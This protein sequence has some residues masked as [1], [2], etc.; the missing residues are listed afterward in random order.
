MTKETVMRKTPR[1]PFTA[2][3]ALGLGLLLLAGTAHSRDSRHILSARDAMNTEAAREQLDGSVRFYFAGEKTPAIASRMMEV[4]A[5]RK[6][7][8]FGKSDT[9]A[10]EWVFLSSLIALRD[11]A[12]QEGGN[13][14]VDI[15]SYYKKNAINQPGKYECAAGAIMAG[16]ALKGRIVR[17]AD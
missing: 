12:L 14:V 11:R 7:N 15:S 9:E 3:I 5:N 6:T 2:A 17:L 1:R 16:V 10:C 13:A 4:V 8:A